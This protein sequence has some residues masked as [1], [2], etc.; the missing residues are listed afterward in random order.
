MLS[1]TTNVVASVSVKSPAVI[2]SRAVNTD[3]LIVFSGSDLFSQ[4]LNCTE[5][6]KKL[7]KHRN[8]LCENVLTREIISAAN[9]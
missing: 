7:T 2:Q 4:D 6:H 1:T 5:R 8:E 3:M 9:T